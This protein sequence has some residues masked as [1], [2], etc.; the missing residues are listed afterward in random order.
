MSPP[1]RLHLG[2]RGRLAASIAVILA[3]ALAVTYV[4]VYRAT[5]SELR[6]QID[7]DLA[8]GVD[9]VAARLAAIPS[10]PAATSAAARAYLRTQTFGSSASLILVTIPGAA[11]VTNQPELVYRG[12]EADESGGARRE[13]VAQAAKLRSAP[14]GYSD[15]EL[16]DAGEVRVLTRALPGPEGG[17]R[18]VIRA[19]EPL[20][21]VERAQSEISRAFALIG[22]LTLLA[23]IAA[24]YL[25]AA[26]TAAPLRRMARVAAEV[27]AG[28]LDHR[29]GAEGANDEVRALAESFDHMLDR[30]EDAFSRQRGFV[31]DASHE[32][33]TPLTAIRG[34]LEVLALDPDPSSERVRA[35]ERTVRREVD[36]MTR[37]VDDLLALARIDEWGGMTSE[38]FEVGPLLE[39][40]V[41]V[42][43]PGVEL[44]EAA[45]GTIRA[46]Q[47]RI[48]QVIRNLLANA[49][50][51]AGA[52]GRVRIIARGLGDRLEVAVEDDGPGIPAGEREL[53][54][55]RFH[56]ADAS[57]SRDSGGSG[58]GL[59][60][61]RAI[62]EAHGGQITASESSLGGARVAFTLP[63]YE[64]A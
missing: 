35:T 9:G 36:R 64:P 17:L 48:A 22:A 33:R 30:L 40:L 6:A 60:I 44:A 46:D 10:G 29:I 47:D 58:L 7:R 38:S 4:A 24:G 26:R 8:R 5:G 55:D 62:V 18:A 57:R 54:F 61:A 13:E 1:G 34:Q 59:A 63:G 56:R 12:P 43:G 15:V 37:L 20:E 41:T 32:L 25:L 52:Q 16:I 14:D 3:V 45:S 27:D 42:A 11:T 51:H 31:S 50:E 23:A 53:I 49:T 21:S 28:E 39:E 19:G 2:L